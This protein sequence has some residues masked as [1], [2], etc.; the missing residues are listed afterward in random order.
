MTDYRLIQ[1][2]A[3]GISEGL[4][5]TLKYCLSSLFVQTPLEGTL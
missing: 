5:E 1:Q 4:Q 2:V 3:T